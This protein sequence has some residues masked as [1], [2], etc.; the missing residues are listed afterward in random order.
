MRSLPRVVSQIPNDLRAFLDRVREYLS[1]GGDERFVTLRELKRGGIVGTTPGGTIT[2]PGVEGVEDPRVPT[3]LV[4]T[5]AF[6]TVIVEWDLPNY[7]GH[8]TTEVWA[9]ATDDFTTKELVGSVEG[10]IFSHS[11]GTAT[12]RYYWIRFINKL[13]TAGPFNATVGTVGQT[14]QDPAIVLDVLTGA[15]T[16]GQLYSELNSRLDQIEV[17][18]T[19][20]QTEATIREQADSALASQIS[21]VSAVANSNTAAIQSEVTARVSGDSANA[22]SIQQVQARLDTGDFAAVKVESATN[23]SE[24]DGIEAKYTVKVDVNGYVAGYGLI[25]AANTATPT[26]EFAV[27]ADRFYVAAPGQTSIIP[28]IVQTTPTTVNGVAVPAGVY[29][30]GAFIENGT[31][32]NAKI[33]AAAIDDAKISSLSAA[34]ITAGTLQVGSYIQSQ[35]YSAGVSG[36][37]INA[38]GAAEFAQ[39]VIRG[40]IFGGNATAY[41]TGT[42][43]FSGLDSA[44]YKFRVGTP[45]GN[46]IA[47]DGS[48]LSV[49][50]T[51][52]GGAATAYATGTGLFS[53][54][55]SGTYRWRVGNPTG[56]RIQ[57]TGSALEVYNAANVLTIASGDINYSVITGTKPPPDAD[58]TS[59]NVAAGIAGQGAFATLDQITAANVSTYIA[60][61]AIGSAQIGDAAITNA[62][63]GNL[64]VD[65]AKIANLT[66][67]TGKIA[68]NAITATNQAYV[69]TSFNVPSGASFVDV[70]GA[71]ITLTNN[72]S[73]AFVHL[74]V[75]A[76]IQNAELRIVRSTNT[77]LTGVNAKKSPGDLG[78]TQFVDQSPLL[79]SQTYKVQVRRYSTSF[80]TVFVVDELI[81]V[82]TVFQK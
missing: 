1:E 47:W 34:K 59:V 5:G 57:W 81:L 49:T 80:Q 30:D 74:L 27:R 54:D 72:N 79:G 20:I 43:L 71:S 8:A 82:G 33:G 18:E 6:A 23:A 22:T 14:S 69:S 60:S 32:T 9:A 36:W 31:I 11:L 63:I 28:F 78:M 51:L 2:E 62:K 16:E 61:A 55:V 19:A 68:D 42:G 4:T 44:V 52:L 10:T 77:L 41:G 70:P 76:T 17:N 3:G 58:K 13:G 37:R 56:A 39:A 26:S 66:I 35:G 46:Q 29:I 25:A 53:G 7:L 15:I 48:A 50:G 21:T 73:T 75:S 45:G 24:I 12:T 65:S 67:G 64:V 38:D 40:S